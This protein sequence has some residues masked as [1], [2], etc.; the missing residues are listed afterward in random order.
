VRVSRQGEIAVPQGPGR[1]YEVLTDR[2]DA[3]TVR[4]STIKARARVLA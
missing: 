2:I 4:R 3:L 1:G